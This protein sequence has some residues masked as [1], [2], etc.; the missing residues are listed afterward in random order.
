METVSWLASTPEGQRLGE[1]AANSL[2][3]VD[4]PRPWWSF[5]L[6]PWN[7]FVVLTGAAPHSFYT[8]AFYLALACTLAGL[9]GRRWGWRCGLCWWLTGLMFLVG[10][11]Q[12]HSWV[13]SRIPHGIRWQMVPGT[14][15]RLADLHCHSQ[16]SGGSLMPEDLLNWHLD[17]GY[18]VVAITD[19][20]KTYAYP[21]ALQALQSQSQPIILIPGEEYRGSTHLLML[22]LQDPPLRAD[23]VEISQAI[24]RA[25]QRGAVV[26]GAHIW[27]GKHSPQQLAD[28]GVEGFEISNGRAIAD[29][30]LQ[31][32][33][34]QRSMPQLGTLD[35]R[36][37]NQPRSATVF[38]AEAD[39]PEKILQALR[40]GHCASLYVRQW[41]EP[42]AFSLRLNLAHRL[43]DLSRQGYGLLLAGILS[44]GGLGWWLRGHLRVRSGSG[45]PGVLLLTTLTGAMGLV[46]V[47]W[48]L[49]TAWFPQLELTLAC[50][51]LSLP[52]CALLSLREGLRQTQ[53]D[54]SSAG[55]GPGH[56]GSSH[57]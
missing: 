33:C 18:S 17:H 9:I 24:A 57:P 13:Y 47:W 34:R 28:W 45:L 46:T 21:R 8:A 23:Q 29:E 41:V 26:I 38:A 10:G 30:H 50:W 39:S 4:D 44:W 52:T 37:G 5:P 2:T 22:G 14:P 11:M 6:E 48:R 36:H 12:A 7:W 54:P 16:A 55:P 40:Q 35:Y 3:L 53:T 32:F 27:T 43:H 42:A 56:P 49:K 15:V 20:N 25:R 1:L 51:S 19:S 31:E